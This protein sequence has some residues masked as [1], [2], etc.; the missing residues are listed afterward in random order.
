[1]SVS[2]EFRQKH[3]K[4]LLTKYHEKMLDSGVSKGDFPI[5]E[6]ILQYQLALV[7]YM[8]YVVFSVGPALADEAN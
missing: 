6:F 2:T 8:I 3:E 1:M 5:H 7:A 4:T